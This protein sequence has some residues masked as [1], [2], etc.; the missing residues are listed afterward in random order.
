MEKI[1][2]LIF[3]GIT[4][5]SAVFIMLKKS[6]LENYRDDI[7]IL[8]LIYCFGFTAV[9]TFNK[10]IASDSINYAAYFVRLTQWSFSQAWNDDTVYAS[11]FMPGFRVL[12]WILSQSLPDVHYYFSVIAALIFA[13]VAF[14]CIR[15]LG[16]SF[17]VIAVI[18][19]TMY[20]YFSSYTALGI[21]QGLALGTMLVFFSYLLEKKK[22]TSLIWLFV[23][24]M[25]HNTAAAL[26]VLY[27][28]I[29]INM[30]I[31][32]L[33]KLIGFG[34]VF[35]LILSAANVFDKLISSRVNVG[36]LDERYQ[37][38]FQQNDYIKGFRPDFVIFSFFPYIVYRLMPKRVREDE[39]VIMMLC[40][41]FTLNCLMNIFSF[42]PYYDRFA[43]YS[44]FITPLFLVLLAKKANSRSIYN[45]ALL[46]FLP[47]S[48][49]LLF[50]VY[51]SKWYFS[52]L[53][54]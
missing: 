43:A 52:N 24:F 50:I 4:I 22:V 9:L 20:P 38:Y 18:S 17:G 15:I 37:L 30:N 46:L 35:T 42:M 40:C 7:L 25:F 53:H 31:K 2:Y 27:F 3:F 23:A 19:Y 49:F 1:F 6:N 51:N 36:A 28:T 8:P 33:L 45:V 54:G 10:V 48:N 41:Y 34:W 32:S 11:G 44:W 29:F 39:E 21:R 47:L 16:F 12:S 5:I 13:L 26:V 14:G